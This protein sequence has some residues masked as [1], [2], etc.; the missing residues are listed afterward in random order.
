M[1]PISG[2]VAARTALSIGE[3]V[4]VTAT[5]SEASSI[6]T[7]S[8]A[9]GSGETI[10][11]TDTKEIADLAFETSETLL[12]E[13]GIIEQLDNIQ[14]GSLESLIARNELA[15][16]E[17][18]QIESNR[19]NG[20]LREGVV[21]MELE[22]IYPKDA[23]YHIESQCVIRNKNGE[24][25]IDSVSDESRRIDFIIIK[26]GQAIKSIEV[27]SETADKSVQIAK[28]NRIREADGNYIQDRR[29]GELISFAP[30]VQTE[31]IRRA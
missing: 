22:K 13:K 16:K 23:G 2:V 24:I 30:G 8:F 14:Y 15:I 26:D 7:S 9:S 21:G 19:I 6:A 3:S 17:V 5:A 10:I 25:A 20:A 11:A 29:T 12:G 4:V 1:E 28:E 31:I 27:T 18:S